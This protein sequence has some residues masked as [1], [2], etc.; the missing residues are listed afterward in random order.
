[1]LFFQLCYA[2]GL[3]DPHGGRPIAGQV[4]LPVGERWVSADPSFLLHSSALSPVYLIFFPCV[5]S[6]ANLQLW[7]VQLLPVHL[8]A[9]RLTGQAVSLHFHWTSGFFTPSFPCFLL[10]CRCLW[11]LPRSRRTR[12]TRWAP[13]A[14]LSSGSGCAR[15]APSRSTTQTASCTSSE[16]HPRGS[17]PVTDQKPETARLQRLRAH[18]STTPQT[19]RP[20]PLKWSS[21]L[22]GWRGRALHTLGLTVCLGCCGLFL[23]ERMC[24]LLSSIGAFWFALTEGPAVFLSTLMPHLLLFLMF[25]IFTGSPLNDKKKLYIYISF[26]ILSVCPPEQECYCKCVFSS[27]WVWGFFLFTTVHNRNGTK[28]AHLWTTPPHVLAL[29]SIFGLLVLVA[30][31]EIALSLMWACE[32]NAYLLTCLKRHGTA[33]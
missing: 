20:P 26:V 6:Q 9:G 25:F 27:L 23:W 18:A 15:T 12:R 17:C 2:D 30:R 10:S 31:A 13:S 7:R 19:A 28:A 14:Q 4:F 16:L 11:S 29:T 24:V 21:D 3:Q 22:C 8:R 32:V 1:M 33:L 5:F